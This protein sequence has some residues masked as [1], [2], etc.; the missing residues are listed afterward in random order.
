VSVTD[1]VAPPTTAPVESETAPKIRP[2][3]PP[4]ANVGR[5]ATSNTKATPT[6]KTTFEGFRE[7]M[8]TSCGQKRVFAQIEMGNLARTYH[9]PRR[10]VKRG[11]SSQSSLVARRKS[12]RLCGA[13]CFEH[14]SHQSRDSRRHTTTVAGS[15]RP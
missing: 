6:I 7:S 10:K 4:C 3:L 14:V 15:R 8:R 2:V 12:D 1:T 9:R 5:G 11:A 13:R